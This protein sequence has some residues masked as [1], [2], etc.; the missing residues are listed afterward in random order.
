[1]T[2]REP[3]FIPEGTEPVDGW[4]SVVSNPQ[5][6]VITLSKAVAQPSPPRNT[7]YTG[8]GAEYTWQ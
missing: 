7:Q 3:G 2:G 8:Q 6:A 5:G 1:M 4:W